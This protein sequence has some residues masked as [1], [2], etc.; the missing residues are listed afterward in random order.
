M[1]GFNYGQGV[2]EEEYFQE[3]N[4][5]DEQFYQYDPY[6][7]EAQQFDDSYYDE[8]YSQEYPQEDPQEEIIIDDYG[9][10]EIIDFDDLEFDEENDPS[11]NDYAFM[12][13]EKSISKPL[14][15]K[16]I[17]NNNNKINYDNNDK[18]NSNDKSYC[19][20]NDIIRLIKNKSK[21]LPLYFV[22]G[23]NTSGQYETQPTA[24]SIPSNNI[25]YIS[26]REVKI[27]FLALNDGG[28]Q[29]EFVNK[30]ILPIIKQ[31]WISSEENGKELVLY[32]N[33][34]KRFHA[35]DDTLFKPTYYIILHVHAPAIMQW[36]PFG[37]K[38][39]IIQMT[40]PVHHF[41]LGANVL[42]KIGFKSIN[43]QML[44]LEHQQLVNEKLQDDFI[45]DGNKFM[46]EMSSQTGKPLTKG[47]D[48][49]WELYNDRYN[50]PIPILVVA[51][52]EAYNMEVKPLTSIAHLRRGILQKLPLP[53][54]IKQHVY[55]EYKGKRMSEDKNIKY[56]Q[57][58]PKDII[59]L[60]SNNISTVQM[61]R[62]VSN[63]VRNQM[64]LS[65]ENYLSDP[66]E[67]NSNTIQNTIQS[68]LNMI[69]IIIT[70]ILMFICQVLVVEMCILLFKINSL[71]DLVYFLYNFIVY[72]ID[73]YRDF[74]LSI[75][76]NGIFYYINIFQQTDLE[77][78]VT[79]MEQHICLVFMILKDVFKI[80]VK[81]IINA[82]VYLIIY[83]FD[84]IVRL[85]RFISRH[86]LI[87]IVF[88]ILVCLIT[89]TNAHNDTF[90][91]ELTEPNANNINEVNVN[92]VEPLDD[93][94]TDD[95]EYEYADDEQSDRDDEIQSESESESEDEIKSENEPEELQSQNDNELLEDTENI[96][97]VINQID[98]LSAEGSDENYKYRDLA[99]YHPPLED[100][101]K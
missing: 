44:C 34:H 83:V 99:T 14:D 54:N 33:H 87:T 70:Q 62:M 2:E 58:Q 32:R 89:T 24:V 49:Q 48:E 78:V 29:G 9:Q 46:D 77:T 86:K 20:G 16:L 76:L 43:Q 36:Y 94:D 40:A 37:I 71:W 79:L 51:F 22:L 74:I 60:N 28:S 50:R 72:F 23:K 75:F 35:A 63:N 27:P 11:T 6:F 59:K 12:I 18:I 5:F 66:I 47:T 57:V 96:N 41:I 55:L 19:L 13:K 91:S 65:D 56:Y 15:M 8:Y 61:I 1:Y 88:I 64:E 26:L 31:N 42:G 4:P 30:D 85:M 80:T 93:E 67:N 10:D 21:Q 101:P 92:A 100:Y 25:K 69:S 82:F 3:M 98:Y 73:N 97:L 38:F 52:A 68:N 81:L 17:N 53:D 39:Y 45:L 7:N 84:F 95:E 90:S